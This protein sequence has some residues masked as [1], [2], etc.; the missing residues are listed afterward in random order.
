LNI[1]IL[2]IS[3]NDPFS[4]KTF[5]DSLKL[6]YP[7]LSDHPELKVIRSYPGVQTHK[8]TKRLFA[9]RGFFVIDK[10]GIVRGKWLLNN[11]DFFPSKTVLKKVREIEDKI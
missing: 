10:E 3:G 11:K 6:P 5:A 2:G 1:Q 4:Q 9:R 7:L 8:K